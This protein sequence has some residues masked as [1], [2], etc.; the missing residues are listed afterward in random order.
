MA[1]PLS[2]STGGTVAQSYLGSLWV[3]VDK[4]GSDGAGEDRRTLLRRVCLPEKTS[5]EVRRAIAQAA[6]DARNLTHVN[7]LSVLEVLEDGAELG[8]VYEHLEA[9]PLRALQASA[10]LRRL[11]FPIAV[12]LRIGIDLLMGL[13]SLHQAHAGARTLPAIGGLTRTRA[14]RAQRRDQ[15]LRRAVASCASLLDEVARTPPSWLR[16]PSM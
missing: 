8:V 12:S 3:A 5:A 11:S 7:I 14:R 13:R 6:S 2:A 10:T 4:R 9:E 1:Q 15:S 16:P